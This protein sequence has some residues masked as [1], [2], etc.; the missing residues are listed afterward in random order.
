MTR[1]PGSQAG[2]RR[3]QKAE[4]WLIWMQD[5]DLKPNEVDRKRA[6]GELVILVMWGLSKKEGKQ[7]WKLGIHSIFCGKQ[8]GWSSFYNWYFFGYTTNICSQTHVG[9]LH[10]EM[11][12]SLLDHFDND[13][14]SSNQP[15]CRALP[16]FPSQRERLSRTMG[17]MRF[18]LHG[19]V[20][21]KHREELGLLDKPHWPGNGRTSLEKDH[22]RRLTWPR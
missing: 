8:S 3:P 9:K 2:S 7:L 16:R 13:I 10:R 1:P 14:G 18:R 17:F 22:S 20:R 4:E 5:N 11:R 6:D 15:S 21:P 12:M 19:L